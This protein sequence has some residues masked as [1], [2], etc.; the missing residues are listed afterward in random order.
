MDAGVKMASNLLNPLKL[1][2]TKSRGAE[3]RKSQFN[4]LCTDFVVS[5]DYT[6]EMIKDTQKDKNITKLELEDLVLKDSPSEA[7]EVYHAVQQ[8]LAKDGGREWKYIKFVDQVELRGDSD[9]SQLENYGQARENLWNAIAKYAEKKPVMFQVKIVLHERTT[10]TQTRDLL[11]FLGN[12]TVARIE[13]GGGLFNTNPEKVPRKLAHLFVG[14]SKSSNSS[15][16][17]LEE[18]V[19]MTVTFSKNKACPP[20]TKALLKDCLDKLKMRARGEDIMDDSSSNRDIDKSNSSRV[21]TRSPKRPASSRKVSG[22]I[23]T[24]QRD[25]YNNM[26]VSELRALCKE[27]G[28]DTTGMIEKSEM[29]DALFKGNDQ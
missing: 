23:R 9:I 15:F 17:Y 16:W 28:I 10:M 5:T 29:V 25:K 19:M 14:D 11:K 8:L 21:R 18:M 6:L 20:R 3:T 7:A 24:S 12:S 27:R 4:I 2:R 26:K 22:G 1:R 13:Y